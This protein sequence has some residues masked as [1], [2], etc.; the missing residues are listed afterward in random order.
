MSGRPRSCC[1][2]MAIL[3]TLQQ[4]LWKVTVASSLASH[5]LVPGAGRLGTTCKPQVRTLSTNKHA[6]H[7]TLDL[8]LGPSGETRVPL[9]LSPG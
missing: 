4:P 2:E 3:H 1:L 7:V 9:S 8:S 5:A 6:P